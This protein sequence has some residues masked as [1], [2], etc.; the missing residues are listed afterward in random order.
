MPQHDI[1]TK[2]VI[3]DGVLVFNGKANYIKNIQ[4]GVKVELTVLM[5]ELLF[6]LLSNENNISTRSEILEFVFEKNE[7]RPTEANLNLNIS[8]LRKSLT[9]VG[10]EKKLIITVPKKGFK[11]EESNLRF[12][13]RTNSIQDTKV[14]S[15]EERMK[16]LQKKHDNKPYIASLIISIIIFS[17]SLTYINRPSGLYLGGKIESERVVFSKNCKIHIIGSDN[18]SSESTS[19]RPDY[20][21]AAIKNED[22]SLVKDIYIFNHKNKEGQL[23]RYFYGVCGTYDNYYRC[24]SHFELKG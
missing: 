20:I 2:L 1:K 16:A 19:P 12:K 23:L 24:A 17:L 3:I 6:F 11:L 21:Y 22:C 10:F 14:N 18:K 15:K 13:E 5:S 9:S 7:A 4:T 8:M